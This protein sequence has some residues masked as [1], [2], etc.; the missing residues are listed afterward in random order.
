MAEIKS[1]VV[2]EIG[3]LSTSKSNWNREVNIIRWNDGKP[4]LD[5]R[6]WAPEHERA[7]KGITLTA[8]EVAVLKEL[9]ADYDPYEFE[10]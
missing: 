7:G 3:I 4:K 9:L 1:E 6:D 8:E 5:I 10:E 2:K